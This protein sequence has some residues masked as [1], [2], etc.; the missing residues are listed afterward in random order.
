MKTKTDNV[1]INVTLRRVHGTTVGVEKQKVLHFLRVSVALVIQQANSMRRIMSSV[2]CLA[3]PY[4][5]TLSHKRYDFRGGGLLII[6][7]VF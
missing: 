2:V 7:Y 4:F 6:K 3:L 1:R 5:T